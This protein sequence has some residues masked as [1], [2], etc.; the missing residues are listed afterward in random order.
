MGDFNGDQKLDLA[1]TKYGAGNG[2][3]VSVLLGNGYGTFASK[4]DYT[5]GSAPNGVAVG[6]FNSDTKLDLAVTN[7]GG[8]SDNTVNVLLGNGDGTFAAKV[9]Y[10]TGNYPRSVAKG[11]FNGDDNPDLAVTNEDGSTVS[12]LLSPCN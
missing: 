3:T 6:D 11:D 5:T 4:V 10:P 8:G 1:V 12:I 7:Y 2:N 9:D